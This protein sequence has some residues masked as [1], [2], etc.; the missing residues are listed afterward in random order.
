MAVLVVLKDILTHPI[1]VAAILAALRELA[2][3]V[4]RNK[5]R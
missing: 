5:R 1:T 4:A 3:T 2:R